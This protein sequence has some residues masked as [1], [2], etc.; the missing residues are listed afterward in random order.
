M[1]LLSSVSIYSESDEDDESKKMILPKPLT[2][3]EGFTV[4][5]DYSGLVTLNSRLSGSFGELK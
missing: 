4:K 2:E 3:K 5:E 1:E